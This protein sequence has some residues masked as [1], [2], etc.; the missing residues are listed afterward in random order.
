M[1][2]ERDPV[3][4]GMHLARISGTKRRD[5]EHPGDQIV[6]HETIVYDRMT[7]IAVTVPGR[8]R[9]TLAYPRLVW[10]GKISYGLYM[11]HEIAFW[12]V[13]R[14]GIRSVVALGLTV[15][16]AG[17]SYYGVERPFLRL[18]RAWTRVP[19]RPV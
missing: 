8:L 1:R 7:E 5:G 19:S 13:G 18:K 4:P 14:A 3:A 11:Y 2:P 15:A 6:F 12:T 16:L 9:A 17:A 10:L